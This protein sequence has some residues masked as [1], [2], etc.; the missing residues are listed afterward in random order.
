MDQTFIFPLAGKSVLDI[1]AWDGAF[2]FEAERRGARRVLAT[3][4]FCWSGPGWGDKRGFDYAHARL[5]SNV[6][7]LDVDVPDLD[8]GRLGTFDVVLFLGV[9]YHVKDPVRCLEVVSRMS[10]E[11]LIIETVVAADDYPLPVARYYQGAEL[12][13]DP[14]NFW[15]PNFP[16]LKAMLGDCGFRIAHCT[17]TETGQADG[18][19]PAHRGAFSLR[20]PWRK[21]R[22]RPAGGRGRLI[23]HA[24]REAAP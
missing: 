3:D 24:V 23:A 13:N 18:L 16:C 7:S 9:L 1:G 17:Y 6:E 20:P 12:N 4:H 2:A 10:D 11:H 21:A 19:P 5:Q 8:P 14:T 22:P 15:A